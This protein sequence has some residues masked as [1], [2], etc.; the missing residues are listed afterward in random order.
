LSLQAR[1]ALAY[2]E[3]EHRKGITAKLE[4]LAKDGRCTVDECNKRLEAVGAIALSLDASGQP[5]SSDVEKWIESRESVPAGTFWD[6]KT[7]TANVAMSLA[8]PSA[9]QQL[10]SDEA[11]VTYARELMGLPAKK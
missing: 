2:A 8:E 5:A 11:A 10:G 6:E 9:R 3:R 7:R 4:Q 1:N